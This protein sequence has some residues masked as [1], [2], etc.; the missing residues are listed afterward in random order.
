MKIHE[1]Q[2]K[3]IFRAHGIPVPIGRA[4]T[5]KELAHRAV[6]EVAQESG[7]DVIVVKAQI[8]A[9]GRGKGGGVKVVKGGPSEVEEVGKALL[10]LGLLRPDAAVDEAFFEVRQVHDA[11]EVLAETHGVE[12]REGE[13]TGRRAGQQA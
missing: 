10:E 5:T 1:Y 2:A 11:G 7:Q 4:A 8:H 9:G 3:D 12:D 6:D 13:P